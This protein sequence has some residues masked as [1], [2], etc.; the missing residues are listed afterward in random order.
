M[1]QTNPC[2]LVQKVFEFDIIF[3]ALKECFTCFPFGH[4]KQT[5]LFEKLTLTNQLQHFLKSI[6]LNEKYECVQVSYIVPV[7]THHCN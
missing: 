4:A 3:L 7:Q 6:F 1:T 2:K 5:L